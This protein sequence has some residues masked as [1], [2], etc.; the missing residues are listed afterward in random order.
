MAE[1]VRWRAQAHSERRWRRTGVDG[2]RGG[3]RRCADSRLISGR[4]ARHM[5]GATCAITPEWPGTVLRLLFHSGRQSSGTSCPQP[6]ILRPQLGTPDPSS[7][8]SQALS[9]VDKPSPA[10]P[11]PSTTS[12]RQRTPPAVEWTPQSTTIRTLINSQL[13]TWPP[14][15]RWTAMRV[16]SGP[17]CAFR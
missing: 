10:P 15:S 7:S 4:M 6:R 13:G 16:Q 11:R 12:A 17:S 14:P 8:P 2:R 5:T 9:T 3:S 1:R